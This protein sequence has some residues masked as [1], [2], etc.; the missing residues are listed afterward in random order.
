MSPYSKP[1]V[2]DYLHRIQP[3]IRYDFQ[4]FYS[5]KTKAT[6]SDLEYDE[7]DVKKTIEALCEEDFSEIPDQD[8]GCA[9]TA[10][11]FGKQVK[12]HEVYIKLEIS[13][14]ANA[15]DDRL[16]LYCWAFHYPEYVMH[17]PMK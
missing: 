8:D 16:T 12:G 7:E 1:L 4:L 13:K 10:W 9:G 5:P 11:V 2:R 15:G 3:L 14:Y 17:Y 6:L